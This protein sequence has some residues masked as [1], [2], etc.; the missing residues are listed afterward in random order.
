[1]K[2]TIITFTNC[3]KISWSE[4]KSLLALSQYFPQSI[5]IEEPVGGYF[6]WIRFSP[7]F[8]S[9]QF[10]QLAIAQGISVASGDL[11]SEQG[12]VD[13]AIRLNFSYE[14]TAE[15]EQALILLAKPAHQLMH[16]L[17]QIL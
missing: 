4:K 13:N 12:R 17:K 15:K 8:D 9:Q 1:M 14:L 6:V 5:E 10:H 7:H 16:S 11:F 2:A 3:V